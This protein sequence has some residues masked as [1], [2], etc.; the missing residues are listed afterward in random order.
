MNNNSY[1]DLEHLQ[2]VASRIVQDGI[3]ITRDYPD[4]VRV[5]FACASL[6]EAAREPYHDICRFYPGYTRQ[7]CDQKFNNC[8]RT[9]RGDITLGTLMELA[10]RHGIDVSLPKGRR[11]KTAEQKAEEEK[12]R[13]IQICEWLNSHYEFRHNTIT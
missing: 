11:P 8:L 9:G 10:K 3:D 5:T 6:G 1:T 12:N 2:L 13:F 4:W 7:E